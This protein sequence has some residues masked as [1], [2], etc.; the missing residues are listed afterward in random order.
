MKK[1]KGSVLAPFAKTINADKSGIY[2]TILSAEAR[3]T[4]ASHI[5]NSAWY[6]YEIYRECFEAVV[7][8]VAKGDLNIC[9]DWGREYSEKILGT[10]YKAALHQKDPEDGVKMFQTVWNNLFSFGSVSG[11]LLPGNELIISIDFDRDF[12]TWYYLA[13]GWIERNTEIVLNQKVKSEFTEK[14]WEGAPMTK[15][16]LTW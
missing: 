6:P 10:F 3:E 8:V 7:S 16:R 4:V 14:S 5:I 1:V 12:E 9:T 15:I 2:D 11:N 13:M